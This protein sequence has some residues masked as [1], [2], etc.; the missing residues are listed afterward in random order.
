MH[1]VQLQSYT[2]DAAKGANQLPPR[3]AH[4]VEAAP[5]G[6]CVPIVVELGSRW[7]L[8]F[9]CAIFAITTAVLVSAPFALS[10][11]SNVVQ[12]SAHHAGTM[13]ASD[14]KFKSSPT[15]PAKPLQPE[16][17][18]QTIDAYGSASIIQSGE[19]FTEYASKVNGTDVPYS[20]SEIFRRWQDAIAEYDRAIAALESS[21]DIASPTIAVTRAQAAAGVSGDVETDADD[22]SAS[23]STSHQVRRKLALQDDGV[24]RA[25]SSLSSSSSCETDMVRRLVENLTP[26]EFRRHSP[27][28]WRTSLYLSSG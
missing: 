6:A 2:S 23:T 4:R 28:T 5:A 16:D 17:K 20:M 19:N 3:S 15:A 27:T 26:L 9:L 11:L 24:V 13:E 18:D 21:Y 12:L 22:Q 1:C 14:N 25:E 7:K 8:Y 10:R